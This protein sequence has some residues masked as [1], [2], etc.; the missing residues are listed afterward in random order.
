MKRCNVCYN[1]VADNVTFCPICSESSFS[2]IKPVVKSDY[3]NKNEN[4]SSTK[5]SPDTNQN[6]DPKSNIIPEPPSKEKLV[7]IPSKKKQESTTGHKEMYIPYEQNSV[8]TMTG[9]VGKSDVDKNDDRKNEN[10]SS[11]NTSSVTK[12]NSDSRSNAIPEPPSK[13]KLVD[14]PSKKKQ[15]STTDHKEMYIPYEQN[16]VGTMTGNAGN[17][18]VGKYDDH[19]IDELEDLAQKGQLEAIEKLN[20]L[21]STIGSEYYD[22]DK[23]IKNAEVA[24]KH[25]YDGAPFHLFAFHVMDEYRKQSEESLRRGLNYGYMCLESDCVAVPKEL[26]ISIM[27]DCYIKLGANL[28]YSKDGFR[29]LFEYLSHCDLQY[30]DEKNFNCLKEAI[31]DIYANL[32][33]DPDGNECFPRKE[34]HDMAE[35]NAYI[36]KATKELRATYIGQYP[37]PEKKQPAAFQGPSCYHHKSIPAFTHCARCGKNICEDCSQVYRLIR[38][39][40]AGK[41]ICY[42]CTEEMVS[43]NISDLTRNRNKIRAYFILSLVGI[44]LGFMFGFSL[45]DG[46]G[47]STTATIVTGVIFAGIGGVFL[48]AIKLFF[49]FTWQAIKNAAI[50]DEGADAFIKLPFQIIGMLL[51]C[52]LRTFSNTYHYI[53]YLVQTS[54]YIKT[55]TEALSDM[56]DYMEFTKVLSQNGDANIEV[57]MREGNKLHGNKYAQLYV[58][59]GEKK[60]DEYMR[61]SLNTIVENGEVISSIEV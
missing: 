60:A 37:K 25:G 38:G 36:G 52:V 39:E 45:S 28:Q 22:I 34:L 51:G 29:R 5:T 40:Y 24:L 17:S 7:D 42:D 57:L 35:R 56:K 16:S 3:N 8:G 10:H 6:P 11:T 44:I 33:Y 15:D 14:I 27:V 55:D 13:E 43:E 19:S 9:N 54:G 47:G 23:A 21:Y 12:Q 2:I 30:S 18:E 20:E 58:S 31:N 59:I 49:S 53:K 41:S 32:G 61:Q 1:E 4:H 50:G 46:A 26:I 48:T